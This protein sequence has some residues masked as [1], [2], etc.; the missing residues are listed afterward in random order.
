MLSQY[1]LGHT[2]YTS[3]RQDLKPRVELTS[4]LQAKMFI[5]MDG[6]ILQTSNGVFPSTAGVGMRFLT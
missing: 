4:S 5:V 1:K 2:S 6:G 3:L